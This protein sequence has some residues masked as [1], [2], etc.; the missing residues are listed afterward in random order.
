MLFSKKTKENQGKRHSRL[1]KFFLD[2]AILTPIGNTAINPVMT[3]TIYNRTLENLFAKSVQ[4]TLLQPH[5]HQLKII[6]C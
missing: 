4:R 3:T 5:D 1:M 2:N 6:L